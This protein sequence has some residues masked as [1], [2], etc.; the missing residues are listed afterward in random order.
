MRKLILSVLLSALVMGI[1]IAPA[2]A[3][4]IGPTP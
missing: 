2:V 1:S 4:G 3:A